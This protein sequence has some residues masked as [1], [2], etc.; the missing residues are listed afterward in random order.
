MA[1]K[2][3]VLQMLSLQIMGSPEPGQIMNWMRG[4]ASRGRFGGAPLKGSKLYI[5]NTLKLYYY[6]HFYFLKHEKTPDSG[7]KQIHSS[8][9]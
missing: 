7:S 4:L 2:I 6:H 8:F 9:S 3:R 5:K 1:G